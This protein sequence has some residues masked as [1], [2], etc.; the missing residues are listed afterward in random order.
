V[1]V[2]AQAGT[3]LDDLVERQRELVT[4]LREVDYWRRLVLARLDLAIAAVTDIDELSGRSA[5]VMI[6]PFGLREIIGIPDPDR[7]TEDASTLLP[8]REVL[9]E[10][11]KYRDQLRHEVHL[12]SRELTSRLGLKDPSWDGQP[13]EDR[14]HD[15]RNRSGSTDAR[16]EEGTCSTSQQEE[17][18]GTVATHSPDDVQDPFLEPWA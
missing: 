11:D 7:A 3:S 5:R 6:P 1:T 8:L 12:A 15:D 9:T 18:G 2:T 13:H 16:S 10:L 17:S 4:Q 14:S